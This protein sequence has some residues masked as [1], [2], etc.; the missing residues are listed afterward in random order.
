MF[1]D[2]G[3]VSMLLVRGHCSF[4]TFKIFRREN[5]RSTFDVSLNRNGNWK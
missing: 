4:V 5:G 3:G 2:I 1:T